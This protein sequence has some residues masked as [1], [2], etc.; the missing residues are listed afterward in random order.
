MVA[1]AAVVLGVAVL[2]FSVG[3]GHVLS[4]GTLVGLLLL[5]VAAVRY[6]LAQGG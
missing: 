6:R 3:G 2:G 4:L 1:T 5:A